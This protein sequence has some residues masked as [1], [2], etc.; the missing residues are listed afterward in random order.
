M[1]KTIF[2]KQYSPAIVV[3]IVLLIFT[4][5]Y[6]VWG[7]IN[8]NYFTLPLLVLAGLIELHNTDFKSKKTVILFF[9]WLILVIT[10]IFLQGSN[11]LGILTFLPI[12][13]IPFTKELFTRR[14]FECFLYLYASLVGISLVVYF[15]SLLGILSPYKTIHPLNILKDGLYYVYP[16]MVTRSVDFRFYGIFDEPG[17]VGTLSALLI[18]ANNFKMKDWRTY[19]LI[20]SGV[21]SFSLFFYTIFVLYLIIRFFNKKEFSKILILA[22]SIGLLYILTKDTIYYELIWR[23]FEWDSSSGDFVGDNRMH[24]AGGAGVFYSLVGTDQFWYGVENREHYLSLVEGTSSFLNVIALYGML[25]S[26]GYLLF[27]HLYAF[28]FVKNIRYIALFALIFLG[29]IYQRPDI[30]EIYMLFLFAYIAR[31]SIT[32][33]LKD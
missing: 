14:V 9:L 33:L 6:F 23:R 32:K 13:F 12:I 25:F 24:S 4:R 2:S 20:I 16:L 7:Y 3:A 15:S 21:I 17:V 10:Y 31:F 26:L 19:I 28:A 29:T 30:F 5:P 1:S 8:N 27:F 11:I 22:S 18:V